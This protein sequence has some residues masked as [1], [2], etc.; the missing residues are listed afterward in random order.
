M[1]MLLCWDASIYCTPWKITVWW[2]LT[3]TNMLTR[4]NYSN[5]NELCDSI[6]SSQ[7]PTLLTSDFKKN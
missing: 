4:L 6:N 5:F 7:L 2:S 3:W 1:E